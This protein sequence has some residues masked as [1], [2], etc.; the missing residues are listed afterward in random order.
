MKP[1]P[2][3]L[4][5]LLGLNAPVGATDDKDKKKKDD[6]L[7]ISAPGAEISVSGE[8]GVNID[9]AGVGIKIPGSGSGRVEETAQQIVVGASNQVVTFDCKG[10]NVRVT[11]STNAVTLRG[12]CREVFVEGMANAVTV[13]TV[14]TIVVQGTANGVQWRNGAGGKAPVIRVSGV[15]NGALRL[16]EG[17]EAMT[18]IAEQ[19]AE[20]PKAPARSTPSASTRVQPAAAP[21]EARAEAAPAPAGARPRAEAAPVPADGIETVT[22]TTSS[23][24]LTLGSASVLGQLEKRVRARGKAISREE[25]G[26]MPVRVVVTTTSG[27]ID[28]DLSDLTALVDLAIETRSADVQIAFPPRGTTD[29]DL[30]SE[31]GNITLLVPAT[32]SVEVGDVETRMGEIKV[33]PSLRRKSNRSDPIRINIKTGTGDVSVQPN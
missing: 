1:L 14:A 31:M 7:R 24:D 11:G 26:R 32:R 28:M 9:A 20:R 3:V 4:V 13:D 33:D 5:G 25:A 21:A 2:W 23:G 12:E 10:R 29:V 6:E 19:R 22:F 17:E 16:E 27:E 30:K 15:T 18:E 8:G